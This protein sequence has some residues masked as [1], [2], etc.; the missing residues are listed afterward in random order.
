M[1]QETKQL[2]TEPCRLTVKSM[3]HGFTLLELLVAMVILVV[4]LSIAFQAFSGTVLGW[5]RGMEVLDGITHGDFAITQLE[6]ALNSTIFFKNKRKTYAFKF[7]KD[8]V[9]GLPGDRISFVTSSGA[10]MPYNSP[11]AKGPHRLNLFI[12]DDKDGPAL[13]A[14]ALPAIANDEEV[15]KK[16]DAEPMLI[17]RDVQGLEI[18]VWDAEKEDWTDLWEPENSIPERIRLTIFVAPSDSEK[19]DPIKFQRIME[20]PVASSVKE[21]LT[22]PTSSD[23]NSSGRGSQ[24]GFST[25]SDKP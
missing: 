17:S 18:L 22:S 19:N 12:D 20:I 3:R 4:A 14:T 2:N 15:E 13:F 10:F 24:G 23:T 7:K 25:A 5:K 9:G 6:S 21:N 16:Y 8:T 11:F 1:K